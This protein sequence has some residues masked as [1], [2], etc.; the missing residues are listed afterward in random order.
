MARFCELEVDEVHCYSVGNF[1][2]RGFDLSSSP[3][4]IREQS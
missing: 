1:Y 3:N 2:D 4:T